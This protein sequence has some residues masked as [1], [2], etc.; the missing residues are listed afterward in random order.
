MSSRFSAKHLYGEE[1]D[2][3][4]L[5]AV[6]PGVIGRAHT[7]KYG[8]LQIFQSVLKEGEHLVDRLFRVLTDNVAESAELSRQH[9]K[10]KASLGGAVYQLGVRQL[11][12]ALHLSHL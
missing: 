6:L 10:W 2:N 9:R 11:A 7:V 3:K 12:S 5:T 1:A 4:P 8:R